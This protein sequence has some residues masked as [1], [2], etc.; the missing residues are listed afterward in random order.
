[1][2]RATLKLNNASH[3]ICAGTCCGFAVLGGQPLPDLPACQLLPCPGDPS[4][5]KRPACPGSVRMEWAGFCTALFIFLYGVAFSRLLCY[6]TNEDAK[7]ISLNLLKYSV[8]ALVG[9]KRYIFFTSFILCS[10]LFAVNI[11]VLK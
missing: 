11:S 9:A 10:Y 8:C 3:F 4:G 6:N 1:M 7:K 5:W 2:F